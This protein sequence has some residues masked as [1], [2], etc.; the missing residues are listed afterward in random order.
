MTRTIAILIALLLT[1]CTREQA[2]E[3]AAPEPVSTEAS[4]TQITTATTASAPTSEQT[5]VI[6]QKPKGKFIASYSVPSRKKFKDEYLALKEAQLLEEFAAGLNEYLMLP[7]N[8]RLDAA[9]CGE[10][11]AFYSP[12]DTKITLCY[13]FVSDLIKQAGREDLDEDEQSDY[14]AGTLLFVLLHEVGHALTHVLELPVTG[15]EEDA[16]DQLATVLLIEE[17]A[18]DEEFDESADFL[19][20]AAYWFASMSEGEYD[21][22]A[23]ADEHSLGEQRYYNMMCWIYGANPEAGQDIVDDEL[24]PES[25]AAQCPD[26]YRQISSAWQRLL[27]PHLRQAS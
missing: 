14:I 18:T 4:P 21:S 22:E 7:R 24:L 8:I 20:N 15:K 10:A 6:A 12:D 3:M 1:A 13:E 19:A 9:E 27:K 5:A 2:P 17:S 25:R 26:E 11:N 23:F 16:V